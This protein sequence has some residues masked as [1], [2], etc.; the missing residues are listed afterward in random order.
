METNFKFKKKIIVFNYIF[1][2]SCNNPDSTLRFWVNDKCIDF[3]MM[4]VFCLIF[5]I[6]V[7]VY[8]INSR[9]NASIF[10]ISILFDF[11]VN[12]VGALGRSK[13]ESTISFHKRREKQPKIKGKKG[14]FK[15]NRFLTKAETVCECRFRIYYIHI[16]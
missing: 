10:H 1:I 6:F 4:F 7:S 16:K 11:K 5:F 14:I 13:F 15:Q 8:T 12:I 3:T 9:N 2:H